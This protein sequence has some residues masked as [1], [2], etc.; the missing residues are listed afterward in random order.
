MRRVLAAGVV[1]LGLGA[2]A[3]YRFGPRSLSFES[4]VDIAAG[5]GPA[6]AA[7]TDFDSWP[8]MWQTSVVEPPEAPVGVGS[9]FRMQEGN[10]L[11]VDGEITRWEPDRQFA[12]R[13]EVSGMDMGQEFSVTF[14][15][16]DGRTHVAMSNTLRLGRNRYRVLVVVMH[17]ILR[18]FFYPQVLQRVK[19]AAETA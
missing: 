19:R 6:F 5:P 2:L 15:P 4:E 18:R 7:F 12:A 17:P 8:E 1:G 9:A 13:L 16:V 3:L 14:S 11:V 10:G